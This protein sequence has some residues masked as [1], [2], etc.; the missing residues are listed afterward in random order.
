MSA[1]GVVVE[2][3]GSLQ[4]ENKG[5]HLHVQTAND[6]F[7]PSHSLLCHTER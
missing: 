4:D 2:P 3:L 6:F 1:G 7:V 5:M